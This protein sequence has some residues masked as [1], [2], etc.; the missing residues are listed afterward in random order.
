MV[1]KTFICDV[2]KKSVGES[3]LIQISST[4]TIP[5][6][7]NGS[8]YYKG[9]TRRLVACNKDVCAD[10]LKSKGLVI[11]LSLNKETAAQ[12]SANNQ[13]SFETKL[14]DFLSDLGVAFME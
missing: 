10:C 6:Q 8:D 14:I 2:C 12:D 1:T 9:N 3:E 4:I 13:K 11:E 7:P 5:H